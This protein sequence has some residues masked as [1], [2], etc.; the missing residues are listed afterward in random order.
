[1]LRRIFLL[2]NIVLGIAFLFTAVR[3]IGTLRTSQPWDISR[4]RVSSPLKAKIG[5][6]VKPLSYYSVITQ[7][8]LFRNS[9]KPQPSPTREKIKVELPKTTLKLKL[10][11]TVVGSSRFARAMIE[12]E[13]TGKQEL[14]RLGE[15]IAGGAEIIGIKRGRVI[16][17]RGSRE[18]VLL[19]YAE[20]E[21]I[22]PG[23]TMAAGLFLSDKTRPK[24]TRPG[25]NKR[26][27]TAKELATARGVT[28][29]IIKRV[30]GRGYKIKSLREAIQAAGKVLTQAKVGVYRVHGQIQGVR[31]TDIRPGSMYERMGIHSGDVI[32]RVDGYRIKSMGDIFGVYRR[33]RKQSLLNVD[34]ERDG[35]MVTLV[36]EIKAGESKLP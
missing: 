28:D 29:R 21:E 13:R 20:M 12:D 16:L 11:G 17:R 26:V 25:E 35:K 9:L 5:E 7:R 6:K 15:M 22:V 8:H 18:E 1:M 31:I 2:G 32:K 10:K 27:V 3:F 34:I 4:P 33:L 30:A 19:M 14:Y 24:R 23:R 36:Y